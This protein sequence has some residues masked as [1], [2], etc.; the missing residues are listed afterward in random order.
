MHPLSN[1][2]NG[3]QLTPTSQRTCPRPRSRYVTDEAVPAFGLSS[4][5]S[6]AYPIDV[7]TV[8]ILQDEVAISYPSTRCGSSRR[9]ASFLTDLHSPMHRR[10][11]GS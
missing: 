6:I 7:V 11:L 8:P 5:P 3:L 9:L 4:T 10:L 1:S 2:K